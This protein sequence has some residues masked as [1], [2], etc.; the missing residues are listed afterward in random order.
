MKLNFFKK[1]SPDEKIKQQLEKHQKA[2]AQNPDD[3]RINVKIAELYLE[4]GKHDKAVD[5]FLKAA[6]AYQQ[7]RISQIAS[8]LYKRIIT[9]DPDRVEVYQELADLNIQNGFIGD[10]VSVLQQLATFYTEKDMKFEADQVLQQIRKIDP[11]NEL[12]KQKVD[13]FYREKNI[14]SD[15]VRAMGPQDKWKLVSEHGT[16]EHLAISEDEESFFDLEAALDDGES[17]TIST[18]TS[19]DG[20]AAVAE[21][22]GDDMSPDDVLRQLKHV[23]DTDPSQETSEFRYNLAVAHQRCKHFAEALE[24]FKAAVDGVAHK[25][26]CYRQMARCCVHLGDIREAENCL[27][28][29]LNLDG[30]ADKE[31]WDLQYELAGIYKKTGEVK[32][33]LNLFKKIYSENKNFRS[34][35]KELKNLSLK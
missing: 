17:I 8:A 30:L 3:L 24:E 33:A 21:N 13:K 35:G 23:M 26:D 32:K 22:T 4:Y 7:K 6:R 10:G 25:A 9:L 34:V 14:S 2:L 27:K 29:G 20:V 28:D 12:I 15:E 16:Q 11:E 18:V 1:K 5:E 19:D 31:R